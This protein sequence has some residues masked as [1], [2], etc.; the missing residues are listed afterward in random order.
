M[1]NKRVQLDSLRLRY[2]AERSKGNSPYTYGHV[3]ISTY[4]LFYSDPLSMYFSCFVDI[5]LSKFQISRKVGKIFCDILK[6]SDGTMGELVIQN[7]APLPLHAMPEWD[8]ELTDIRYVQN[9]I[10]HKR[11]T[12]GY[13]TSNDYGKSFK[14]EIKSMGWILKQ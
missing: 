12:K 11:T 3:L 2:R 7:L 5:N 13:Y 8:S 10:F 14:G 6:R 1:A 9:G 4:L